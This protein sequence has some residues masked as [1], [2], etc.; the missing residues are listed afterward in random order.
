MNEIERV[1]VQGFGLVNILAYGH[2]IFHDGWGLVRWWTLVCRC[3]V[4]MKKFTQQHLCGP[5]LFLS[6]KENERGRERVCVYCVFV[7]KRE[8]ENEMQSYQAD[9][10]N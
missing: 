2:L 4:L 7:Y 3:P 6:C 8:R 1:A 10:G 5:N 9:W